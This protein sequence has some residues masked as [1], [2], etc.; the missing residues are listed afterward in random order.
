MFDRLRCVC[1]GSQTNT[2]ASWRHPRSSITLLS[3][4][5]VDL[6]DLVGLVDLVGLAGL[7]DLAESLPVAATTTS[8]PRTVRTGSRTTRISC[9][10]RLPPRA[11]RRPQPQEGC[12]VPKGTRRKTTVSYTSNLLLLVIYGILTDGVWFQARFRRS[13]RISS[14]HRR[15]ARTRPSHTSTSR[16][17]CCREGS[18]D[19]DYAH[20]ERGFSDLS[21]TQT[22][23]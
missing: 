12:G 16:C 11:S 5:P 22:A 21:L 18:M 3:M 2:T 17:V 6:A 9:E 8:G 15:G 1:A 13:R 7:V 14:R 19:D 23:G 10:L 20:T 4:G